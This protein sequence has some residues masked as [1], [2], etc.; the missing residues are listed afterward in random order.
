MIKPHTHLEFWHVDGTILQVSDENAAPF[1][2]EIGEQIVLGYKPYQVTE[3]IDSDPREV[4]GT[5][6]HRRIVRVK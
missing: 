5:L 4:D 1:S 3:I 2:L 6:Y